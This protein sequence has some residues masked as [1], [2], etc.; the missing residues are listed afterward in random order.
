MCP[1]TYLT[2]NQCTHVSIFIQLF[3]TTG[4]P[5]SQRT[6]LSPCC[7]RRTLLPT[8]APL[9]ASAQFYCMTGI[10]CGTGCTMGDGRC[11]NGRCFDRDGRVEWQCMAPMRAPVPLRLNGHDSQPQPWASASA[12]AAS[13]PQQ[14][15][16]Q[17]QDLDWKPQPIGAPIEWK[18]QFWMPRMPAWRPW[19]FHPFPSFTF[20]KPWAPV[21][22]FGPMPGIFASRD[23][24]GKGPCGKGQFCDA[25][26]VCRADDCE[27]QFKHGCPGDKGELKK[28]SQGGTV[29]PAVG[30]CRFC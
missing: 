11:I 20:W 27:S 8:G 5:D 3:L 29:P 14:Q 17:P 24:G 16:Q 28:V 15:Q 22:P 13:T 7:S 23:C 10:P 21:T 9:L 19:S 1:A 26:G 2:S 25:Q 30:Y 6:L 12:A 18:A 4:H